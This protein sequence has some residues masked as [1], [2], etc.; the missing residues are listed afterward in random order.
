M[1]GKRQHALVVAFR[2]QRKQL[3]R[4]TCPRRH[5]PPASPGVLDRALSLTEYSGTLK[6]KTSLEI[7]AFARIIERKAHGYLGA[8]PAAILRSSKGF[9]R[10]APPSKPVGSRRGGC[11]GRSL[12]SNALRFSCERDVLRTFCW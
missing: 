7:T 2:Q 12:R 3:G 9:G 5:F 8:A 4:Q 11:H 10:R 1:A 6:P